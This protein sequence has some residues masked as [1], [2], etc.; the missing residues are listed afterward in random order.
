MFVTDNSVDSIIHYYRNELVSIYDSREVDSIIRLVFE[1]YLGYTKIDTTLN[2][3]R[4]LT[5]SELL[6]FHFAL[7]QLKQKKPIQYILGDTLFHGNVFKVNEAVLIP[8]PETEELVDNIIK[9]NQLESPRILDI[10]TGSGCIAISLKKSISNAKVYALD[11]SEKALEV[12]M[13]N[14]QSNDVDI[15]FIQADILKAEWK[16][17]E[18]F[19]IVVSNP[20]YVLD[21]EKSEMEANVLENEPHLALFVEDDD[22]LLFYKVI[23]KFALAT[24]NDGGKLWFEANESQSNNVCKI[25]ISSNFNSVKSIKDLNNKERVIFAEK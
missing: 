22:P 6:Q 5:E 14:A 7:K 15:E 13:S 17:Q 16:P 8:R 4:K 12:A 11:L 2:K 24:L 19:D 3:D 21:S 10:G 18:K 1:H 23:S 9:D 20:P 25:L